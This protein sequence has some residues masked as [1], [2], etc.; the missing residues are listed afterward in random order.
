MR[1]PNDVSPFLLLATVLVG[2]GCRALLDGDDLDLRG[3][4][5][6]GGAGAS[7]SGGDDRP[8]STSSTDGAG[9]GATGTSTGSEATTGTSTG[10][11]STGTTSSTSTG[12]GGGGACRTTLDGEFPVGDETLCDLLCLDDGMTCAGGVLRGEAPAGTGWL[13]QLV[14]VAAGPVAEIEIAGEFAARVTITSF[15]ETGNTYAYLNDSL[16]GFVVRDAESGPPPDAASGWDDEILYSWMY[17]HFYPLLNNPE[18]EEHTGLLLMH[19]DGGS[20][21]SYGWDPV[22]RPS[23][24]PITIGICRFTDTNPN[25]M[26]PGFDFLFRDGGSWIP[27]QEEAITSY[28]SWDGPAKLGLTVGDQAEANAVAATFEDLRILRFSAGQYTSCAAALA[29][30]P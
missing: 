20:D 21:F 22:D 16:A 18:Q 12:A 3:A 29:A 24:L 10:S 8:T 26:D 28:Q 9:A 19:S 14:D 25:T 11:T 6:S 30:I 23:K 5:G 27:A 15:E 1:R 7:G 13:A 2:G 4:E 17:G